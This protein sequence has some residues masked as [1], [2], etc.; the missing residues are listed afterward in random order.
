MLYHE[1]VVL[2]I[3]QTTTLSLPLLNTVSRWSFMAAHCP[4]VTV[5][6][7]RAPTG[8]WV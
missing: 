6:E 4:G 3:L 2:L 8:L 5:L 7:H 1:K